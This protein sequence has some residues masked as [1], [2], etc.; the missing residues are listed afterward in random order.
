METGAVIG[1]LFEELNAEAEAQGCRVH[2]ELEGERENA[3][4]SRIVVLDRDA[5]ELAGLRIGARGTERTSS[6]LLLFLRAR[7]A[8]TQ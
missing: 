1:P 8:A 3:R 6:A 5:G 4:L 7:R 2:L